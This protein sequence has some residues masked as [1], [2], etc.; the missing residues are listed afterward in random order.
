MKAIHAILF[1]GGLLLLVCGCAVSPQAPVAKD[2]DP[3]TDEA[4]AG[5]L[6]EAH[7]FAVLD[8]RVRRDEYSRVYVVGEVKNTGS[9]ARTVELQATLRNADGRVES[10][11][12]FFPASYMNIQ[13]GQTW[14]FAY[15]F[16]RQDDAAKAELRI[17]GAVRTL[18]ILNVAYEAR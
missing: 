14:P 7:G 11:G 13:P 17:V 1:V 15:S 6:A 16:G 4:Q 5:P 2:V 8:F 10:V 18:D 12:H 3:S 9:L